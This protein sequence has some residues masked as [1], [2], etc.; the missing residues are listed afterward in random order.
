MEY[1]RFFR[2]P[3]RLGGRILILIERIFGRGRVAVIFPGSL[4]FQKILRINAIKEMIL[5][6]DRTL[7]EVEVRE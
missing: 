5:P 4:V 7:S 1:A 6:G 2:S 3:G